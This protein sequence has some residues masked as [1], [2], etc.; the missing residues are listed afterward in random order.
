V[1]IFSVIGFG[2]QFQ[3][4]KNEARQRIDASRAL[5]YAL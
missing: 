3:R 1:L 4:V 5:G 2:G